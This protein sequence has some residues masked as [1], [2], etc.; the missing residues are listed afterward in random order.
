MVNSSATRNLSRADVVTWLLFGLATVGLA[1]AA[2]RGWAYYALPLPLRREAALHPALRP[3]GWVGHGYGIAGTVLMLT[4]LLYLVRRRFARVGGLGSMRAWL[5]WHVFSGLAGAALIVLHSA[6]TLRTLPAIASSTALLVVVLTGLTGRYLYALVPR[7]RSGSL[8]DLDDVRADLDHALMHL[9]AT[10]AAGRAAADAFESL[11]DRRPTGHRGAVR[12]ALRARWSA[13]ALERS[14]VRAA[15]TA[16]GRPDEQRVALARLHAVAMLNLRVEAL[17]V[18]ERA[19]AS[20]RSLH[21][22]LALVMLIA[23][24]LHV[25]IAVYLGYGF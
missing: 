14:L 16:G 23:A 9:R 6:L 15:R 17:S 2:R 5:R 13:Y 20:W 4:N 24:S 7:A 1:M 8:R 10:G 25:S 21:R 3:S 22:L 18:L 12:D 11:S 19:A